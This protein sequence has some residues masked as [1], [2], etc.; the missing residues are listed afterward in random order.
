MPS[1]SGL[2]ALLIVAGVAGAALLTMLPGRYQLAASPDH[3]YLRRMNTANGELS[4]CAL[5]IGLGSSADLRALGRRPA[6]RSSD[7][8]LS[9]FFA[10]ALGGP[11]GVRIEHSPRRPLPAPRRGNA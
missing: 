1:K 11:F 9:A 5:P 7:D 2:F 10:L 6:G 3:R 4:L 8:L